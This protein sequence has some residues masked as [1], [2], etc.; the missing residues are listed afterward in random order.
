MASEV[1]GG[2]WRGYAC[3]SEGC[4]VRGGEGSGRGGGDGGGARDCVGREVRGGEGRCM[5]Q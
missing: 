1:V 2:E 3:G 5:P 4:Q